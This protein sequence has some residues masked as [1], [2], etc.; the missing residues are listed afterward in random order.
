MF[1]QVCGRLG[2][3]GEPASQPISEQGRGELERLRIFSTAGCDSGSSFKRKREALLHW[4][5]IRMLTNR[6]IAFP[7]VSC[8]PEAPS[9]KR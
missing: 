3:E 8:P 6:N 5:Q 4:H 1:A 2:R 9:A 7:S